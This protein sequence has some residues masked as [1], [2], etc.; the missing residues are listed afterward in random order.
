MRFGPSGTPL[1]EN[2]SIFL[3]LGVGL[4][5]ILAPLNLLPIPPL[6]GSRILAGF[7]RRARE[8]FDRPQAHLF[9]MFLF[10]AIF[11]MSPIGGLLISGAWRGTIVLVDGVGGVVGNPAIWE[12]I[13]AF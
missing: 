1:Y 4:N 13:D 10:L 6:D 8:L 2:A 9:G 3:F 12:V 7:S 11:F 5:L